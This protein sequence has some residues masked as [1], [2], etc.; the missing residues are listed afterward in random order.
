M[1]HIYINKKIINGKYTSKGI[2]ALPNIRNIS[3]YSGKYSW[4]NRYI[5]V[6]ALDSDNCN[7]V[8][9]TSDYSNKVVATSDY[10]I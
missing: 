10:W 8:V 6:C 1:Y 3:I 2:Y 4:S 7:K 5:C 9:G